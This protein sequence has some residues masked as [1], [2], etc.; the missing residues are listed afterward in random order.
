MSVRYGVQAHPVPH[1]EE[2]GC[3]DSALRAHRIRRLLRKLPVVW[4][5]LPLSG[6]DIH[7]TQAISLLEISHSASRLDKV[8]IFVREPRAARLSHKN[9]YFTRA[10]N[11]IID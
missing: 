1:Q 2:K 6:E 5:S 3:N 8:Q 9:L 4:M 7:T 11:A 10:G